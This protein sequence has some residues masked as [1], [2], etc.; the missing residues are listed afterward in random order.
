MEYK[1]D[2]NVYSEGPVTP[3]NDLT[4]W[5]AGVGYLISGLKDVMAQTPD[6]DQKGAHK[7]YAFLKDLP[8]QKGCPAS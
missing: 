6:Q 8:P 7:W 3:E 2:S 5:C 1:L 4:T